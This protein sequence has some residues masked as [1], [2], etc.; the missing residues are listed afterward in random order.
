MSQS[1]TPQVVDTKQQPVANNNVFNYEQIISRQTNTVIME[2]V[3]RFLFS[4]DVKFNLVSTLHLLRT[5]III[6][7]V[8]NVLED[9]FFDKFKIKDMS[10]VKYLIQRQLYSEKIYEIISIQN[11]W[12]YNDTIISANTLAPFFETHGVIINIPGTY[13]YRYMGRIIKVIATIRKITIAIPDITKLST[14]VE[15]DIIKHNEEICLGGKTTMYRVTLAMNDA[16]KLEPSQATYAYNTNNYDALKNMI[17]KHFLLDTVFKQYNQPFS[18][19]FNGPPGTGKTTFGS[20]IA[21]SGIF[22]RIILFNLVAAS[23]IEF[24]QLFVNLE[25]VIIQSNAKDKKPDEENE[26]ILLIID[27]VDKWLES[28]IENKINIIRE[29][30]RKKTSTSDKT[31]VVASTVEFVKLTVN[32]EDDKRVQLKNEFLDQLYNIV[33]GN[34]LSDTKKYVIIFNTND[35]DKIFRNTDKRYNALRDRFSRFE[36]KNNDKDSIIKY[37][38]NIRTKVT[39]ELDKH[40]TNGMRTLSN[41]NFEILQKLFLQFDEGKY[42][43]IPDNIDISFRGLSQIIRTCGFNL[44]CVI[45]ELQKYNNDTIYDIL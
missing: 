32:E 6:L 28:Y 24:K 26:S 43:Q 14:Y 39:E 29:E 4:G 30:S 5:I 3:S 25:R 45:S 9:S 41:E 37:L 19:N 16:I 23:K 21:M 22:N 35:F 1:Y 8:K 13:Y 18:I 10:F 11:K 17:Q 38:Q 36:F 31:A 33:D 7:F 15:I 27:E 42:N 12:K 44:E 2:A 34:S 20:F 40:K